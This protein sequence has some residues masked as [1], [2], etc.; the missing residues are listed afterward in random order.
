MTE[1]KGEKASEAPDCTTERM[2][3]CCRM[4]FTI[5]ASA[6][7]D[8]VCKGTKRA[9]LSSLAPLSGVRLSTNSAPSS[10]QRVIPDWYSASQTGQNI[11]WFI[12]LLFSSEDIIHTQSK[13]IDAGRLDY[14][15]ADGMLDDRVRSVNRLRVHFDPIRGKISQPSLRNS[16]AGVSRQF[17]KAIIF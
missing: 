1:N 9:S 7:E 5:S 11:I 13:C 12:V 4:S 16:G 8:R 14:L 6:G 17:H 10:A 2:P 3:F 15:A